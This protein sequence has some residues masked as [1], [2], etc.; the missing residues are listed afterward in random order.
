MASGTLL[1][2]QIKW[3]ELAIIAT[4]MDIEKGV[5]MRP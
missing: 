1:S 2:N 5:I 3:K 4:I